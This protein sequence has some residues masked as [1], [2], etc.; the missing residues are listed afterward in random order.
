MPFPLAGMIAAIVTP[1]A[2]FFIFMFRETG[3]PV[4]PL[5]NRVFRSPYWTLDNLASPGL[6]PQ[7]VLQILLWPF[8]VYIYP[9]R[10]SP[11]FL[12]GDNPYTGRISLAFIFAA[13]SLATPRMSPSVKLLGLVTA[14]SILLWSASSGNLRYG[15]FAE[16]LGGILVLSVLASLLS[17]SDDSVDPAK[18]RKLVVL[19]LSFSLLIAMQV[20]GAYR[21]TLTLNQ[22]IYGDKL[23]PTIF[24][25]VR[26]FVSESAYLF[27]D[28]SMKHFLSAD[29]RQTVESID[30]WVNSYPTT[31][32]LMASLKPEIPI[33]AVTAFQDDLWS[34]DPLKTLAARERYE[35]ARKAVLGKRLY[36]IALE[37]HLDEALGYLKRAGLRPVRIQK[38]QLPYY[39]PYMHL[40]VVLIELE[41]AAPN[42]STYSL[43]G[44]PNRFVGPARS[45]VL[46]AKGKRFA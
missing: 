25:D 10:G 9:E 21:Q 23:Q 1:A 29:E 6:G 19:A 7:S 43:R 11:E 14:S 32:G 46:R 8:W 34:F 39:S 40:Q 20:G 44:S 17:T 36:S 22:L 41:N 26:G 45:I 33:I 35:T 18:R 27:R 42:F 12:G 31:V 4:F 13:I 16:V 5:Y 30:I 38:W 3:N 37:A 2:P 24:Q 15:I 28:R